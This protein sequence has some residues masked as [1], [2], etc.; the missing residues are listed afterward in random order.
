MG[1]CA[2]LLLVVAG[3]C[4]FLFLLSLSLSSHLSPSLSSF[5]L[6]LFSF[7][8]GFSFNI[9]FFLCLSV[10]DV[11]CVWRRCVVLMSV[12]M[13]CGRG[14]YVWVSVEGCWWCGVGGRDRGMCL[15]CGVYGVPCVWCGT[16]KNPPCV[17]SKRHR[18]YRQHVHMFLYMWAFGGTHGGVLN[19]HRGRFESTHGDVFDAYT[20]PSSPSPL[21]TTTT[22]TTTTP[23]SSPPPPHY[24]HP[25]LRQVA[26]FVW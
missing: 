15:V 6:S 3:C 11:L 9:F 5:I 14:V 22:T 17:H 16:L 26:P 10:A 23:P 18:V 4:F 25:R 7:S 20:L 19:V 8:S 1:S 13:W 21:P 2:C 12:L 24:H